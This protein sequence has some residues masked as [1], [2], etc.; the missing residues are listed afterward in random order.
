MKVNHQRNSGDCR[1]LLLFRDKA[2]SPA[3]VAVIGDGN[4]GSPSPVHYSLY[5]GLL[6]VYSPELLHKSQ[7]KLDQLT[8]SLP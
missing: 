4:P 1:E 5:L 7:L 8:H 6:R 3:S 2:C